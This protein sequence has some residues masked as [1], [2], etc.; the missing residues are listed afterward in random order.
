MQLPRYVRVLYLISVSCPLQGFVLVF[1]GLAISEDPNDDF[2]WVIIFL[3]IVFLVMMVLNYVQYFL[4]GSLKKTISFNFENSLEHLHGE[5][6]V[7]KLSFRTRLLFR[8]LSVLSIIL[9]TAFIAINIGFF[10]DEGTVPNFSDDVNDIYDLLSLLVFYEMWFYLLLGSLFQVVS[11]NT[12]RVQ[13]YF[14][15]KYF[16]HY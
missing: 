2:T 16:E 7:R 11:F 8:V 10:V 13:S 14:K 5:I 12:R 9:I 3:G 4:L 1:M 15:K 6:I